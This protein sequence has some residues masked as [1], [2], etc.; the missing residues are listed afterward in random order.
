MDKK[1]PVARS[2]MPPFEEYINEIRDIWES[3]WLTNFGPKHQELE[4]RLRAY[5]DVDHVSLIVNGHQGLECILDVLGLKG[6]I[7]TT[8]YT[9][10]STTHAILRRNCTPV[11]CDINEDDF[12]MDVSKIESLITDK[13][14]AIMPVHVY[15]NICDTDRIQE[16]A[17]RHGL[18]VIYDAAHAFGVKKD[19]KGVAGLGDMSMFSFHATKVFHSVEGGAITFNGKDELYSQLKRWKDFGIYGLDFT[20]ITGGNAKMNEFSA[21]MGLCNLRHIDEAIEKRKAAVLRYRENLKGV[22]GI[23][24]NVI[25]ENVQSNYS[26]FPIV[27]H[28]DVY[29]RDRDEL[30]DILAKHNILVRKYFYPLTSEMESVSNF[31]PIQETKVAKYMSSSVLTLPIYEEITMEDVD[32]VCDVI[33]S[34]AI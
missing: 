9:F 1:I 17:D 34:S 14:V 10:V 12:T 4:K 16:I 18:K 21:A 7:I 30:M 8:P 33:V 28:K 27:V 23:Q 3:R 26:Y 6:E 32:K 2:S 15:G 22:K 13:T 5:L 29:G 11:F 25:Q 24:M 20:D 19:G 31:C